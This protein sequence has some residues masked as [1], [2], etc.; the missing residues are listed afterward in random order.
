[1][2]YI[3]LSDLFN[4]IFTPPSKSYTLP[5][6]GNTPSATL[7]INTDKNEALA[8]R[9]GVLKDIAKTTF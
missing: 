6:K 5:A 8:D 3:N 4:S 9:N 7:V 2:E 1:M